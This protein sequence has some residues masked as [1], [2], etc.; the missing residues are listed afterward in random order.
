[1]AYFE[2]GE[3]L[4]EIDPALLQ[5]ERLRTLLSAC[6][7][8]PDIEVRELRRVSGGTSFDLIVV[9]A[10]DGT[11]APRNEAGI[12]RRERL[13]LY[14]QNENGIPFQVRALRRDFPDT[15]HQNGVE[16]GTP[17]SLCLYEQD[18][19]TVERSWT[20]PKLLAQILRW[21]EKTADGTLH[22]QDQ[23][24]E[25]VFYG[26]GIQLVLP[27]NFAAEIDSPRHEL[28]LHRAPGSPQRI[29]LIGTVDDRDPAVSSA[30]PFQVLSIA[31]DGVAHPP[32]QAPPTTLEQLQGL[33]ERVGTSLFPALT[34]I[35]CAK[36]RDGATP[37]KGETRKKV[38]LLLRVPRLRENV[39]ERIDV[40][41]FL[42]DADLAGLGL[43]LGVL[44]QTQPNGPAFP[45]HQLDTAQTTAVNDG[46]WSQIRLMPMDLRESTTRASARHWSGISGGAGEFRGIL[47]GVGALGSTLADLWA[48]SGWGCWDYVDPDLIEP[49]NPIRHLARQ[50]DVGRPKVDVV[51]ELT[52]ATL[53]E[54][55]S[56]S[57]ALP[58]KANAGDEAALATAI[59]R[60]SLLVDATTT[61]SVPRDW[62]ER[63][64]PR[65]ASVF[66]TP[67][68]QASVLLLEDAARRVRAASLEAQYYRAVLRSSWGTAHLTTESAVRRTGAGCRDHSLVLSAESILLHA[69]L[70]SRRLRQLA[71]GTTA[72]IGVWSADGENGAVS[73]QDVPVRDMRQLACGNWKIYWDDGLDE[74]LRA[75]RAHSLPNETGGIL[76]GVTDHK[77]RTIHLVDALS[78]PLDSSSSPE[79][80]TRGR[81]GVTQARQDCL[82]R[83][84]RMV[85]YVGEWHSHP[86]GVG[87]TPSS[88]DVELLAHLATALASDGIPGV[89]LIVGERDLSISLGSC[90][91][92]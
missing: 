32:I 36:A 44:Q 91:D 54:S 59:A 15:L 47:A 55:C 22:A 26:S 24:L 78:A 43:A 89:M 86:R 51:R 21:L 87:A 19:D 79:G 16:S 82:A 60:A 62:S 2:L 80:F 29:V 6:Q 64:V 83:T 1:M 66:L 71:D 77:L 75:L 14:Y 70:L 34:E 84:A 42:L 53:G 67:S 38:M 37:A 58:V 49:H 20:A 74:H 41:G 40:L 5:D 10:G 31:L 35:I 72:S 8:H 18:W 12:H 9:E 65:T 81:E 46:A 11:V 76:L 13:A 57:N 92:V 68:G 30:L 23:A 25:Q 27:A 28:R 3:P 73:F 45:F 85:D 33:L 17:K 69:A 7:T 56:D 88:L 52:A 63:D 50:G 90:I 39:R 4:P 48:R 61:L